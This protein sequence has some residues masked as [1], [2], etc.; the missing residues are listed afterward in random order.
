M[1]KPTT[2]KSVVGFSNYAIPIVQNPNYLIAD[3]KLLIVVLAA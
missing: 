1:Q 2:Y 3:L